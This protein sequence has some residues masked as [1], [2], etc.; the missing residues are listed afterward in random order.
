[1]KMASGCFRLAALIFSQTQSPY[2]SLFTVTLVGSRT[3]SNVQQFTRFQIVAEPLDPASPRSP[4]RQGQFH[5]F[6][7]TLT[8]FH[9]ECTNSV[10]QADDLPKS[11]VVVMW[12]AP[13]AGSGCVLLKLVGS[14]LPLNCEGHGPFP[15]SR[16]VEIE[17]DLSSTPYFDFLK[18]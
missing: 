11:E 7:D 2:F 10:T 8:K 3:H 4:G 18:I 17:K 9:E 13:P 5:L 1:M 14:V 12:K 15:N 16:N 6:A